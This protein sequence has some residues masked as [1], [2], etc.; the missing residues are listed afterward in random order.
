MER[1][2]RR[3]ADWQGYCSIHRSKRN[4]VELLRCQFDAHDGT[5]HLS[6]TER[7]GCGRIGNVVEEEEPRC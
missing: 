6:E 4:G 7:L 3:Q 5:E 2:T 1:F